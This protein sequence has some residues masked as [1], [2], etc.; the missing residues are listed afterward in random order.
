MN[1]LRR[2]DGLQHTDFIIFLLAFE[3]SYKL[4]CKLFFM[5]SKLLRKISLNFTVHKGNSD[6]FLVL[7]LPL[8]FFVFTC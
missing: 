3:L 1:K 2:I 5:S 7:R 6:L 4:Q 8:P